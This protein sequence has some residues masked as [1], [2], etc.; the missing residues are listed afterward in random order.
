MEIIRHTVMIYTI[1]YLMSDW[2][3]AFDDEKILLFIIVQR[4]NV[5]NPSASLDIQCS[6]IYYR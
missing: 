2:G 1:I 3:A 4:A 5:H 6:H